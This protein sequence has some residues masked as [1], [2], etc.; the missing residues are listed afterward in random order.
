MII[1]PLLVNLD[2]TSATDFKR[3]IKLKSP[4][5]NNNLLVFGPL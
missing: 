1:R 3:K 4:N 5:S 2:L